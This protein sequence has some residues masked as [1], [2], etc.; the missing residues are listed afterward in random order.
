LLVPPGDSE[1][2]AA[3]LRQALLRD[4]DAERIRASSERFWWSRL[5]AR[6]AGVYEELL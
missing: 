2:L 3:A 4:W 5:S 6:L 1:A